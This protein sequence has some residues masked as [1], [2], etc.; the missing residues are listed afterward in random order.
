M[1]LQQ[2]QTEAVAGRIEEINVIGIE[3]GDYLLEACMAGK[4][5]PLSDANGERL[6]VRSV[7]EARELL[8]NVPVESMFLVH[9]SVHDEMCGMGVRPEQDLKVAISPR[10]TW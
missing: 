7:T 2:L 8:Q 6:R 1:N 9:W 3:G 4:P 10:P 5:H